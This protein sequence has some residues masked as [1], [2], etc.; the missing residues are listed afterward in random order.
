KHLG[1]AVGWPLVLLALA[2]VVLVLGGSDPGRH[3]LAV[4]GLAQLLFVPF[5]G[6][7]A[8]VPRLIVPV[9]PFVLLLSVVAMAR[10][11][12]ARRRLG[13]AVA[14]VVTVGWLMAAIPEARQLKLQED[15]YYPELVRAG[16]ELA[17]RIPPDALVLD[18]KP[19]TAF[20]A[21][22]R[23]A[24]TTPRSR[25]CSGWEGISLSW[26]R[27]WP[28]SSGPISCRWCGIRSRC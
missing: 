10:L 26:T 8:P 3:R 15:G 6:G 21:G 9:L 2:G 27:R 11:I 7:V 16:R 24:V 13:L 5:F 22:C 4:A 20:Y 28:R 1:H 19:Y 23:S 25:P 14:G 18:R 17:G 12:G